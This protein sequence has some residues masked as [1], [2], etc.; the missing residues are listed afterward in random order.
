MIFFATNKSKSIWANILWL[1]FAVCNVMCLVRSDPIRPGHFL[2]HSKTAHAYLGYESRLGSA[3]IF[4]NCLVRGQSRGNP[5]SSYAIRI[6]Q[7]QCSEGLSLVLQLK[8]LLLR[9]A[10]CKYHYHWV[11]DELKKLI[12]TL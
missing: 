7:L 11:R 12:T 4:L 1:G 3:V 8:N 2:G 9:T 5:S 6:A 10:P